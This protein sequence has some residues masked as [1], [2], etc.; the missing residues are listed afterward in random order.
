MGE[1][2]SPSPILNEVSPMRAFAVISLLL[3]SALAGCGQQLEGLPDAIQRE[4]K[5]SA[6]LPAGNYTFVKSWQ[7]QAS[8]HRTGRVVDDPDVAGGKALE[9]QLEQDDPDA[10]LF[11]PYLEDLPLG[12]Y[13]VFFRMK[14]LTPAND[15]PLGPIDACVSFA[16]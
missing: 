8:P 3:L 6:D 2:P 13:V 7:A 5:T 11:G 9:A 14:L 15:E 16:Q 10:M 4:V 12:N 1:V